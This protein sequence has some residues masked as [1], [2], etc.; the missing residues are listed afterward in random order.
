MMLVCK[1]A[2]AIRPNPSTTT[3]I[4]T[5]IMLKPRDV[6]LIIWLFMTVSP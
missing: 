1:A 4:S 6:L 5:S 2:K 3:A